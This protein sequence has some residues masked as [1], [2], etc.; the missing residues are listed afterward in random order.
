MTKRKTSQRLKKL[1]ELQVLEY[2]ERYHP[3]FGDVTIEISPD[4]TIA[5]VRAK[6]KDATEA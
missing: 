1:L 5:R 6:L 3:E 4:N 2:I